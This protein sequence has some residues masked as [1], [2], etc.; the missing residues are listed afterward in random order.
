MTWALDLDGV[1]WLAGRGIPGS[2]DAVSELR[3]AG[4]RVVFLTNNSGPRVAE[5]VAALQAV[6]I[7]CSPTDL[8][9]SAQA[10]ASMVAR[11]TRVAVVGDKGI[12]EA[13]EAVGAVVVA[14]DDEPGA[15][16]VGR[17][18]HLDYRALAE[19][20]AA[21]REGA[22]FLATNTDATFP[23]RAPGSERTTEARSGAGPGA[24]GGGADPD[25]DLGARGWAPDDGLLP[26]AGA[27]VAFVATACGRQP[28]V[29]GKPHQAMAAL[30][31]S[32]F[33]PLSV[34]VGDRPETDGLF[35]KLVGARFALVLSGVTNASE[36][37]VVPSP[38]LVGRDLGSLVHKHLGSP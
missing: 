1:V 18:A 9:T 29:A 5:H 16:V 6:G 8:A 13:L 10:V 7:D 35:A 22:R 20:S 4:E 32:R 3:R 23:A 14:A 12:Y 24:A 38:D 21:V 33:G 15:V 17:S 25:G 2:A 30:V 36:L 19:A 31:R 27:V 26:G 11:G 37:P 34:V 28:E